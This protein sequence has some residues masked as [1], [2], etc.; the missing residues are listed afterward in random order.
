MSSARKDQGHIV[1]SCYNM[2]TV[3][4]HC[5]GIPEVQGHRHQV[6]P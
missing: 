3:N 6:W 1:E 2:A 4:Q 5:E